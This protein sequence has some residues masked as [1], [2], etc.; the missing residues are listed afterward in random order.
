MNDRELTSILD[1]WQIGALAV[2]MLA[3]LFSLVGAMLNHSQFFQSFLFAWLFWIGLSLGALVIVMMQNLTGGMWG[4]AVRNLC[5]AAIMTLP[6]LI[7]LFAPVLFGLH[8]IYA[9]SNGVLS[10][11]P[12]TRHKQQYLNAPFFTARSI[13]YFAVLL[14]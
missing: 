4:L 1:R 8:H 10:S 6:L 14:L 11:A 5:L 12:G 9:W 2:G 7:V 13:V 3:A